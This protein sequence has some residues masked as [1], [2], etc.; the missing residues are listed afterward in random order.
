MGLLGKPD[1]ENR[2]AFE[3]FAVD[4]EEEVFC[5]FARDALENLR[6]VTPTAEGDLLFYVEGLGRYRFRFLPEEKGD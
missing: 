1:D 3:P 5:W 4:G 6:A 2:E